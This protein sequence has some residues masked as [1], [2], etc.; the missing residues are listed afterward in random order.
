MNIAPMGSN[1]PIRQMQNETLTDEKREKALAIIENFDPNERS[2]ESDQ[3]MKALFKE[4]GIGPSKELESLL[5][6]SGFEKPQKGGECPPPMSGPG[7]K[8]NSLQSSELFGQLLQAIESDNIDEAKSLTEKITGKS[9]LLGVFV[10][11]EV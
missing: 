4:S 6:E 11:N 1:P 10:D 9:D 7:A 2:R 5:S 8:A 3:L